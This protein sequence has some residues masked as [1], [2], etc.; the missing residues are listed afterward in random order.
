MNPNSDASKQISLTSILE[1]FEKI[2]A[3][4]LEHASI[5]AEV[6]ITAEEAEKVQGVFR[7]Y[8]G[9]YEHRSKERRNFLVRFPAVQVLLTTHIASEKYTNGGLWPQ[10]AGALE[11]N[12]TQAFHN[13]WGDSFATNLRTL[14]LHVFN[15]K[16]DDIGWALLGNIIIHCGIPTTCLY[17]Y[18]TFINKQRNSIP[19][20]TA[21]EFV[22]Y[23]HQKATVGQLYVDKPIVRLLKFG[24]SF[25]VDLTDRIFEL[26]D[27]VA[28]GSD[29]SEIPLPKR[30]SIS[31]QQMYSSGKL[32][33]LRT[34][35][36][37]Q[38]SMARPLLALDTSSNIPALRLPSLNAVEGELTWVVQ[39][40]VNIQEITSHALWPGSTTLEPK[41]IPIQRP[42]RLVT[43]SIKNRD[44]STNNL[45]VVDEHD[46]FIAFDESGAQLPTSFLVPGPTWLLV[47][48]V[49]K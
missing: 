45:T 44:H 7:I 6:T 49:I 26:L 24:G 13:D 23:G 8:C 1:S 36:K 25:A 29:G 32:E 30:F 27:V 5:A 15:I 18:Y 21:P 3:T 28:A 35:N 31:A 10:L 38:H 47:P 14:G 11:V 20:I 41:I 12:N 48:G 39:T 34:Q 46:P 43:V 33:P 16:D 4:Q 2:W 19:G 37:S 22:A 42:M 40:D 17:D 9:L